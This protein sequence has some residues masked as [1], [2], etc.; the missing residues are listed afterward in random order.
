MPVLRLV[1]ADARR[2][3]ACSL[4]RDITIRQF[5]RATRIVGRRFSSTWSAAIWVALRRA[6]M[7]THLRRVAP[8]MPS[9]RTN[10]Q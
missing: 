9:R 1:G 2:R 8:A 3:S 5:F 6:A 4:M 10:T 7:Y